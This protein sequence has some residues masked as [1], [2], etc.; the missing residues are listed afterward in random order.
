MSAMISAFP[1]FKFFV[2][3]QQVDEMRGANP[4]G[5]ED[6]VIKHN[7]GGGMTGP[8]NT[9]GG[10]DGVGA[11]PGPPVDPKSYT[12]IPWTVA[13]APRALQMVELLGF[14]ELGV[15]GLGELDELDR[16]L[17]NCHW[18]RSACGRQ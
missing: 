3:G 11:P 4:R 9:L 5:L 18:G 15:D 7:P 6:M 1:T 8:G 17:W 10:W 14:D 12:R 2:N 13:A 16:V